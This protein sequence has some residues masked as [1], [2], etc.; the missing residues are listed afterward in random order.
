M[1]EFAESLVLIFVQLI[2]WSQFIDEQIWFYDETRT[3]IS[4]KLM[5]CQNLTVVIVTCSFSR[6][7]I[8]LSFGIIIINI[9]ALNLAC[10][11][12]NAALTVS[13]FN[14]TSSPKKH[15][16][17]SKYFWSVAFSRFFSMPWYWILNLSIENAKFLFQPI[18][19]LYAYIK[20]LMT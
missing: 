3:R 18:N 9:I 11:F 2:W 20:N 6:L 19:T 14:M 8:S 12:L 5:Q 15:L 4:N 1:N 10:I 7:W 13:R 17:F 16:I